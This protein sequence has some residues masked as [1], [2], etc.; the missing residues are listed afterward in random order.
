MAVTHLI[1]GAGNMGGALLSGWLERGALGPRNVAVL[2]P[3]PGT[4]AVFA[5]ERGARHLSGPEDIPASISTVLMA[6]KPQMFASLAGPIADALPD[7][8]LVVSIMA[9]IDTAALAE[10]FP[11]AHIVRAMPN[12]P[13]SIGRGVT[14][15]VAANDMD[16]ALIER[17]TTL[18]SA[19]GSVLRV[20]S[21]DKINAVTAISGSGPAYVFHLVEALEAAGRTL[22]LDAQTAAT[23]ARE[24]VTGASALLDASE[25]TPTE[26][27]EAVTSPNGTTQAALNELMSEHGLVPLMRRAARAAMDRSRELSR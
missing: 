26:L 6:V 10:R 9:G 13:A 7:G 22:G 15:Y 19:S 2:D 18:L 17:A 23:L 5:I 1:V 3:T 14:A 8:A 12:T 11:A 20:D 21:D 27:R 16:E 24:T 4:E 25:R